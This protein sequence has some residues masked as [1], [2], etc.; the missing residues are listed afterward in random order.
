VKAPALRSLC[1]L[2]CCICSALA[3]EP[4]PPKIPGLIEGPIKVSPWFVAA[5]PKPSATHEHYMF[6]VAPQL[7]YG[8][9]GWPAYGVS[10]YGYGLNRP[11][12]RTA[13]HRYYYP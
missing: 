8:Y 4:G 10:W 11:F 3:D 6:S 2:L 5:Q 7:Y 9:F 12:I 13:P 1:A